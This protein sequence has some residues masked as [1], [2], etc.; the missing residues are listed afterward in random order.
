MGRN[1]NANSTLNV[2]PVSAREKLG[3]FI[4]RS[5]KG[6]RPNQSYYLHLLR[7]AIRDRDTDAI[8]DFCKQLKIQAIK[9]KHFEEL[10]LCFLLAMMEGL[11]HVTKAFFEKGF[12]ANPN[13]PIFSKL[14]KGSKRKYIPTYPSYFL[15][16]VGLGLQGL[17]EAF[18][19]VSR[20]HL[21]PQF[22]TSLQKG[23][24]EM[25][26]AWLGLTPLHVASYVNSVGSAPMIKLLLENGADASVCIPAEQLAFL[27]KLKFAQFMPNINQLNKGASK[28][29]ATDRNRVI[30]TGDFIKSRYLFA[31]DLAA[32]VGNMEGVTY[33]V[34][35]YETFV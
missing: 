35:G 14:T 16:A 25:N 9:K 18:I 20:Q 19:K 21:S 5:Q 24:I 1:S 17:V 26:Q 3:Q 31:V 6:N 32:A 33:I 29:A 15:I 23:N 34:N 22:L 13:R 30:V 7:L 12:P 28:D 11:E 4:K 10:N 8:N 27:G 2:R